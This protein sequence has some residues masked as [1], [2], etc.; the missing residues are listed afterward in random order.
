MTEKEYPRLSKVECREVVYALKELRG[1]L[2]RRHIMSYAGG[3]MPEII[4]NKRSRLQKLKDLAD[5]MEEYAQ[6]IPKRSK[7][8]AHDTKH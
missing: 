1:I 5:L 2:Q 6:A 4:E 8:I 7:T 3:T